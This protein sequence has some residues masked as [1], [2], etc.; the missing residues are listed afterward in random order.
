MAIAV[1]GQGNASARKPKYGHAS[2]SV[3]MTAAPWIANCRKGGGEEGIIRVAEGGGKTKELPCVVGICIGLGTALRHE[4][5]DICHFIGK[6]L[7]NFGLGSILAGSELEGYPSGQREQTVNLSALPSKVR[8]L[9]PPPRI[10]PY[11]IVM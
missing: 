3:A 11:L 6:S 7:T 2:D 9:L 10:P 8:I 5:C 1:S 4:F